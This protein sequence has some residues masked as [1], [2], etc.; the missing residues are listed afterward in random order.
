MTTLHILSR[1]AT[2]HNNCLVRELRA[3]PGWRV[4]TWYAARS[5]KIYGWRDELGAHPDT[6][7]L[8]RGRDSWDLVRTLLFTP[9]QRVMFIGYTENT[10]RVLMLLCWLVGRRF[11]YWTDHP[12]EPRGGVLARWLRRAGYHVLRRGASRVLVVGRRTKDWFVA[13]GFQEGLVENFPIYVDVPPLE[14][15]AAA[16]I[17]AVRAKYGVAAE[18][19]LVVCGSR[20]IPEKGFDVAIDG[21]SRL[22]AALRERTLL[23]IVGKG[24]ERDALGRQVEALG[25]GGRILFEEWMAAPDFEALVAASDVLLHPARFDAFGGGTL[26]AMAVGVPV[27]GSNKAGAVVERVVDGVN[28]YVFDGETP[29]ELAASLQR[30]LAQDQEARRRMHAA[31]RATAEEWVPAA[32]A[33]RLRELALSSGR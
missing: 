21:F 4:V 19:F 33:R 26:M 17:S 18:D 7:Y 29:G 10:Y 9:K 12:Q 13:R 3:I 6:R 14:R 5:D 24:P 31:A 2:P 30:F 11:L 27:I 15:H 16:S 20:L 28:G 8:E 1:V 23:V 32:G 22:P 25:L